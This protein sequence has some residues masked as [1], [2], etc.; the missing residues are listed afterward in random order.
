MFSPSRPNHYF[1]T[2]GINLRLRLLARSETIQ[3]C[4]QAPG[5]ILR[6]ESWTTWIGWWVERSYKLLNQEFRKATWSSYI[7]NT[8]QDPTV[9]PI[10]ISITFR[11]LLLKERRDIFVSSE[12]GIFFSALTLL[13]HPQTSLLTKRKGNNHT[14]LLMRLFISRSQKSQQECAQMKFD[15]AAQKRNFDLT[16]N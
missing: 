1:C 9:G 2:F 5:V 15:K 6:P 7:A 12:A 13:R 3:N 4:L 14:K 16:L 11:C 10:N 8:D